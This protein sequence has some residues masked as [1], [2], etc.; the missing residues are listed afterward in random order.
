MKSVAAATTRLI[1]LCAGLCLAAPPVSIAA[2][3]RPE[4][5][6]ADTASLDVLSPEVSIRVIDT[7]NDSTVIR[8]RAPTSI[9]A[10]RTLTGGA[11]RCG[12]RSR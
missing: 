6:A 12:L 9:P 10:G 5:A 8:F 4:D 1:L 11:G 2:Q 3:D 7:Y